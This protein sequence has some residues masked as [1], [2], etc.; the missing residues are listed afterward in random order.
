[1]PDLTY[2][3]D[4]GNKL[5]G[6]SQVDLERNTRATITHTRML[7]K[8]VRWG[9]AMAL[10]GFGYLLFMTIYIIRNNVLGNIIERCL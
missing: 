3:D 2:K 6:F 1:M 8:A 5:Y 7:E 4:K 9:I 10:L